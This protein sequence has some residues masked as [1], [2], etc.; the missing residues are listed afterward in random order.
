[1][2][3][4]KLDRDEYMAAFRDLSAVVAAEEQL[5]AAIERDGMQRGKIEIIGTILHDIDNAVTAMGTVDTVRDSLRALLTRTRADE[6]IVTSQIYDHDAR[7]RSM[8]LAV[9]AAA[10]V[11]TSP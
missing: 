9:E 4:I 6:V 11:S 8:A 7:K 1:V 3:L 10:A 2:S 5:R